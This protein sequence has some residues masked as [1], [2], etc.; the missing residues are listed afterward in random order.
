MNFTI[1]GNIGFLMISGNIS[2]DKFP[3]TYS[4]LEPKFREKKFF[5]IY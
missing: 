2:D 4:M 3:G 5:V 1:S